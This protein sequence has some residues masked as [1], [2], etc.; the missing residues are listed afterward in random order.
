[1]AEISEQ[2]EKWADHIAQNH[3]IAG[4]IP[5]GAADLATGA[6][7]LVRHP[8]D[9]GG[10]IADQID[11]FADS[12]EDEASWQGNLMKTAENLP[13]VGGYV[14]QAEQSGTK[15]GNP[16]AI[17]AGLRAATSLGVGP[18]LMSRMRGGE[19]A[20]AAPPKGKL[21]QMTQPLDENGLNRGRSGFAPEYY[22]TPKQKGLENQNVVPRQ[23]GPQ[24]VER[25]GVSTHEP[26][27]ATEWQAA[28]YANDLMGKRSMYPEEP[29]YMEPRA[30]TK[31][32][33]AADEPLMKNSASIKDM[34]KRAR[35]GFNRSWP[36]ELPPVLEDVNKAAASDAGLASSDSLGRSLA[37]ESAP[38][39]AKQPHLSEVEK[40]TGKPFDPAK[41]PAFEPKRS[42]AFNQSLKKAW[43][44]QKQIYNYFHS[45][46]EL[47]P[48][49]REK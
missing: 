2:I 38:A 9:T 32:P 20:E 33:V 3:P 15:V 31:P 19:S 40:S 49:E 25:S 10:K 22:Q 27:S 42:Y 21:L 46:G 24:L 43:L 44:D 14:R 47:P 29:N 1:M 23:T 8:L 12:K 5:A 37:R 39:P 34:E 11:K 16:Q 18:Y 45:K 41:P 6:Y 30:Y 36:R 13:L 26:P 35:T 4:A 48:W 17:G 7:Q 28:N